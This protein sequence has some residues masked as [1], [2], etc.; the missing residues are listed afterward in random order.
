MTLLWRKS[1]CNAVHNR[2]SSLHHV[3]DGYDEA[4]EKTM[5]DYDIHMTKMKCYYIEKHYAIESIQIY[6]LYIMHQM[7]YTGEDVADQQ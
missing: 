5:S 6:L 4:A 3:I 7:N 2:W 1:I